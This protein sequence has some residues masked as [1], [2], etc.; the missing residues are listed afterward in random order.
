MPR[1]WRFKGGIHPQENKNTADHESVTMPIPKRVILPLRQH[2]GAICKPTVEVGDQVL[3]GQVVADSTA[4]ISVPIHASVSGKVV[5]LENIPNA[6]G[7]PMPAMVIEAD[8]L[9]TPDPSIAPIT[10]RDPDELIKAIRDSGL[11]GLGGAGFPTW[12]KLKPPPGDKL[13]ILLINGAECES[14]I[15]SDYREMI[16]NSPGVIRGIKLVL[17]ILGIDR[18]VIGV[19]DNKQIGIDRLIKAC[20]DE[21]QISVVPLKT[22]YPQGGEKQLIYALTGRRVPSGGLPSRVG[23]LVLSINTISFIDEYI[24]TGMPLVKRRV[25][26]DGDCVRNPKN[27]WVPVG[28]PIADVFEFCG[29]FTE[30]PDKLIMGG[31]MMGVTQYSLNNSVLKQTN[32]LLAMTNRFDRTRDEYA[33]LRCGKCADACPMRL[34]PWRLN[35]DIRIREFERAGELHLSDCIECGCCSYVCPSQIHLVQT[36]RLGKAELQKLRKKEKN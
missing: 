6:T 5:G 19:E 29:G 10:T 25:T 31:P 1:T 33:C 11:V 36:F 21:P 24:T 3:V 35:A 12:F 26:V 23:V 30:P 22:R 18:A 34:Q 8:R 7:E 4:T 27:V 14:Y 20:N 2:I 32:A 13:D 17:H 9:Q 28:T 16:E 15:T